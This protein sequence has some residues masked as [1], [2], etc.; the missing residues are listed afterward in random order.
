MRARTRSSSRRANG[1]VLGEDGEADRQHHQARAREHEQEAARR[2]RPRLPAMM[3]PRRNSRCALRLLDGLLPATALELGLDRGLPRTPRGARGHPALVRL[4][5]HGRAALVVGGHRTGSTL[6]AR[7]RAT[8]SSMGGWVVNHFVAPPTR[9]AWFDGRPAPGRGRAAL[10]ATAERVHDVGAGLRRHHVGGGAGGGGVELQQRP[11]QRLGVA[12]ELGPGPVGLELPRAGERHLEQAGGD[13]GGE[14]DGDHGHRARPVVVVA[15]AEHAG[16]HRHVGGEADRGG[17]GRG[18]R[19]DQDVAVAD[20]AD[21]VGD[22]AH[23]LVAVAHGDQ[24]GGDRHDRVLGVAAGG[25]G[26]GLGR[27]DE[28]HPRLGDAG[29]TGDLADGQV[30]L[31]GLGL[32][33]R[34]RA[35]GP[36]GER[37]ALPVGDSR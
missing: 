32:R 11:G 20:V 24:A 16:P 15:P 34:H 28:V 21:L 3:R 37:V 23:E 12:H 30:Q 1:H 33:D 2:G 19:A 9:L 35:G 22:H 36:H 6:S 26:V 14:G 5:G 13:R 8:R 7:N 4:T 10:G 25:E 17:D 27:V 18:D 31:G 29:A